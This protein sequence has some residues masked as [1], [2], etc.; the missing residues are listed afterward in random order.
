MPIR[1]RANET[2]RNYMD[3]DDGCGEIGVN[4]FQPHP[5]YCSVRNEKKKK[6]VP[7]LEQ[8]MNAEKSR[9]FYAEFKWIG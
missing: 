8:R 2:A 9:L 5:V 7:D 3:D 6:C 4:R 1:L